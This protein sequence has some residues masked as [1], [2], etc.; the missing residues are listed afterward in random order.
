M[1]LPEHI[2]CYLIPVMLASTLSQPHQNARDRDALCNKKNLKF[3]LQTQ[4]LFLGLNNMDIPVTAPSIKN[5]VPQI[6]TL[7]RGN[8]HF[9]LQQNPDGSL[10]S[11]FYDSVRS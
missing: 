9:R 1:P 5:Y 7:E 8:S 4:K 2:P 11:I 3:Q 10:P 6:A